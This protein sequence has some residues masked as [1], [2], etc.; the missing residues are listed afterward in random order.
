M[1]TSSKLNRIDGP[2]APV[3]VYT[4]FNLPF[5]SARHD[6]ADSAWI[7]AR[8]QIY[9][10]FTVPSLLRQTDRDFRIWLDCRPGSENELAPHHA[11]LAAAGVTST[12]DRGRRLLADIFA[13]H[14]AAYFTRIDSDDMYAPDAVE[15][16]RALQREAGASQFH[17]GYVYEAATGRVFRVMRKSPPFYTLRFERGEIA[18]ASDIAAML[19]LPGGQRGHNVVHDLFSPLRLPDARYCCVRHGHN[20][21]TGISDGEPID[22]E[23]ALEEIQLRFE[24][25]FVMPARRGARAARSVSG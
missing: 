20:D 21:T 15:L 12:F 10:R 18:S 1:T 23:Q 25:P 11:A 16:I 8:I 24:L 14:G 3:V 6:A 17:G 22:C 2:A 19:R 7:A 13:R 5:R 4:M 9:L